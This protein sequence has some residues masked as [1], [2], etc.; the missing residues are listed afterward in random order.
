MKTED[1]FILAKIYLGLLNENQCEMIF[2]VYQESKNVFIA[3]TMPFG[4]SFYY[5]NENMFEPELFDEMK[6]MEIDDPVTM[7]RITRYVARY[8]LKND[9]GMEG[10]VLV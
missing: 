2:R 6:N 3:G 4:T 8:I 1:H 5:T 10:G 7:A 9:S